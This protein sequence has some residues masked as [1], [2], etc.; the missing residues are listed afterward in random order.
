M[1]NN[2]VNSVKNL[3]GMLKSVYGDKPK[4]LESGNRRP[5]LNKLSKLLNR[6]TGS[7]SY[8]SKE[9]IK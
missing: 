5:R 3:E 7:S 2:P 8:G 9:D 4:K 6:L 1:A